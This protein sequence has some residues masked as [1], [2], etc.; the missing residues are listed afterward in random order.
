[1][2]LALFIGVMDAR[3]NFDSFITILFCFVDSFMIAQQTFLENVTDYNMK[4]TGN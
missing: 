4:V 2:F 3:I 1:M